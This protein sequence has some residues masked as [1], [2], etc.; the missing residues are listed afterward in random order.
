[1]SYNKLRVITGHT[2][3]GLTALVRLHLDHNRIEFIHPDAFS[4][5][6]SL[7]LLHLEANHLQKLHPNTFSTF[8]LLRSFPVSTLRHLYLSEN[9]LGT[10]PRN[11][12]EN[13]PQLENLF[14][15]ANPWSCDCRMSWL[16]D[17]SAQN[18][19]NSTVSEC[20]RV[21]QMIVDQISHCVSHCVNLDIIYQYKLYLKEISWVCA[22]VVQ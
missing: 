2:F 16:Q 19:G 15:Y 20:F 7:R 10:L 12:L 11:M 14:L 6:T 22:A 17:W 1:M 21:L 4:G 8:S 3:S 9:L 5:L 13:M 18:P